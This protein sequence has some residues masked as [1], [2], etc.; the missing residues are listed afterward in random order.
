MSAVVEKSPQSLEAD[1]RFNFIACLIDAVG[2]PVGMAFF[3]MTT[4]IPLFMGYL[5]ANNS[6]IG[7]LVAIVNLLTFLPGCMMVGY[8]SKLARARG[9]LLLVGL[10]ERFAFV[11]LIPLTL[12]WGRSHPGW[13][14]AALFGA[15]I[16]NAFLMGLNQPS[17]WIVLGKCVPVSRRGRLFGLAGGIGGVLG[18]AVDGC[19][20][21]LLN[22]KTGGFPTGFAE[23]FAIGFVVMA[24]TILPLGFVRESVSGPRSE[25]DPHSGHYWRDSKTVWQQ[26]AGFRSFLFSQ[27]PSSFIGIAAPFFVLY[28]GRHLYAP[29]SSVAEYTAVLV[30]AGSFGSVLWGTMSDM[31]GNKLVLLSGSFC[32]F[33]ASV[34]ALFITSP[35][36]FT[37]VFLLSALGTAAVGLAGNNITLEY[38]ARDR[39]IPLYVAMYNLAMALPRAAAPLIGGILADRAGG[40][41]LV[42]I[43]SSLIAA[44]S[45][46]LSLTIREPR[47]TNAMQIG[48]R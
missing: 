28:A 33:L 6:L 12:L 5:K 40:Y 17:Y 24:V 39:D 2:W 16:G 29:T 27:V 46:V 14:L 23:V 19:L 30:L 11:P 1:Q 18:I 7:S 15:F 42:F 48:V 22:G 36:L 41:G 45:V 34:C 9:Y 25:E 21:T 47:H 10:G 35:V 32:S 31:K 20:R 38:A 37:V 3:S 13:L 26:N 8:I 44:A 43:L 4:V